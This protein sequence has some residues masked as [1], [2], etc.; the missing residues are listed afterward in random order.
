M[1]THVPLVAYWKGHRPAGAVIDDLIDFTD[2]YPTLAEAA[3]AK[4]A[5]DDPI[6]GRSFLPRLRG[7][8][9]NPRDWVLWHYQP[10]WGNFPHLLSLIS[11]NLD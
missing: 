5:A 9:G 4:L 7:E 6:D 8:P 11:T 3:A 2:F 1:G 10:Y